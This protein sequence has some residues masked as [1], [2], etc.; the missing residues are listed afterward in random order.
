MWPMSDVGCVNIR[1]NSVKN[2]PLS[3]VRVKPCYPVIPPLSVLKSTNTQFWNIIGPLV[4]V[5]LDPGTRPRAIELLNVNFE[6]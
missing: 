3:D 2:F 4:M 1:Y 5:R 6:F